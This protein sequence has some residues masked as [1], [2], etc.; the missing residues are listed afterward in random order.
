MDVLFSPEGG[1]LYVT[2]FSEGIKNL[3]GCEVLWM[4]P[5]TSAALDGVIQHGKDLFTLTI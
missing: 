3:K 2:A 5:P 4:E 1:V